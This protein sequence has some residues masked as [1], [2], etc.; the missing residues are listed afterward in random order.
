[1]PIFSQTRIK[2][3]G[4]RTQR[5]LTV[6]LCYFSPIGS[7]ALQIE[8][9]RDLIINNRPYTGNYTFEIINHRDCPGELR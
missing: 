2:K 3:E 8:N 4:L 5:G 1:M 7:K 6:P 9:F